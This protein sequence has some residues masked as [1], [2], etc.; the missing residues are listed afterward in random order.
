[1]FTWGLYQVSIPAN[2]YGTIL[3]HIYRENGLISRTRIV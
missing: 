1:M 3:A 2:P